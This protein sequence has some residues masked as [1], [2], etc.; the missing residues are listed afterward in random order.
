MRCPRCNKVYASDSEF[1][2]A[3]GTKL[4][5]ERSE[6]RDPLVGVVVDNRFRLGSR[7]GEGG[8]GAVYRACQLSVNRDVAIK[9]LNEAA[10][11]DNKL[12]ERFVG[13]A[14]IIAQ[15][16]HPNTLKLIDRGQMADGR[17]YLVS[18]L[19]EGE[20]LGEVIGR[21]RLSFSST[22]TLLQQI[23]GSLDEAHKRGIVHRDLK[24][25]NIF[26]QHIEGQVHVKVLDFGIAKRVESV[27]LTTEGVLFGTPAYMSPEQA[28][29][30]T[31]DARSDL[32]A[33]GVIAYECLSGERPFSGVDHMSVLLKHIND[34]P[35]PLREIEPPISLSPAEEDFVL[36]L[37]EKHPD[38]RFQTAEEIRQYLGR[39]KRE[40]NRPEPSGSTPSAE[41]ARSAVDRDSTSAPTTKESYRPSSLL[42]EPFEGH[43]SAPSSA[44]TRP[45]VDVDPIPD[46]VGRQ[47]KPWLPVVLGF[48]LVIAAIIGWW[49][50]EKPSDTPEP[51]TLTPVPVAPPVPLPDARP[52]PDVRPQPDVSVPPPDAKVDASPPKAASKPVGRH[53]KR[54]KKAPSASGPSKPDGDGV[55]TGLIE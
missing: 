13:E 20:T 25:A 44:P 49:I 47:G 6:H 37:L 17:L 40:L 48:G 16:K 2:A 7:I 35:R 54:I 29:G 14:E 30:D 10:S 5:P 42:H 43:G 32:Y 45:A 50:I 38:D 26:L 27:T 36:R 55:N 34:L 9:I 19:L 8:F 3:D 28:K 11:Q 15:L 23:C 24:P 53:K 12:V 31:I 1:C 51:S 46:D 52:S 4:V 39:L 18:E 41:P 22:A 33:L 21:D